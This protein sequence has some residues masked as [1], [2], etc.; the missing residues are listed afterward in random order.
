MAQTYRTNRSQAGD[1]ETIASTDAVAVLPGPETGAGAL[2]YDLPMER[3][4]GD[5]RR[6]SYLKAFVYGNFR[7][8]RRSSRREADAHVFL[9]DWHE[10]RLFMLALCVLI[11]SCTDALFTLN[12]LAA[13]ATE[14]NAVMASLLV[15]GIDVF[16][17]GKLCLTSFPLLILVAT[18]RRKF[19]G[20]VSVEHVLKG[21]C[22]VYILVIYYEIY[23]F[24]YVFDLEI[25][26]LYMP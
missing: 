25:L 10:P 7:P 5:N 26:P 9:F 1:P 24:R 19:F 6:Q 14:A 13:G 17:V 18:A 11:L 15:R 22:V 8:R 23:L 2:A 21:F 16:L 12:L 3:R 20:T 4:G